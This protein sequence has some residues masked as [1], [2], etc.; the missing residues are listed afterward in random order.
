MTLFKKFD[1]RLQL[2]TCIIHTRST[3]QCKQKNTCK[4]SF[5]KTV[6][7]SQTKSAGN[8]AKLHKW[9]HIVYNGSSLLVFIKM[10]NIVDGKCTVSRPT[11][12]ISFLFLLFSFSRSCASYYT[13]MMQ[14]ADDSKDRDERRKYVRILCIP[15][16]LTFP[17]PNLFSSPSSFFSNVTGNRT[18][19]SKRT[20]WQISVRSGFFYYPVQHPRRFFIC[21]PSFLSLFSFFS[22]FHDYLVA[23]NAWMIIIHDLKK[24]KRT[25]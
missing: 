5:A 1:W 4:Y 9:N 25:A 14:Y 7:Q 12:L 2:E 11:N 19:A 24:K 6:G 8:E 18:R 21:F 22:S 3:K 23:S 20:K 13:T 15:L 10:E 17:I 16:F